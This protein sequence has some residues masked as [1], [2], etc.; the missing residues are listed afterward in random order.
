M[1]KKPVGYAVAVIEDPHYEK[2]LI[3]TDEVYTATR[4]KWS[5]AHGATVHSNLREARECCM[6]ANWDSCCHY[7]IICILE[8]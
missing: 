7:S 6:R 4:P 1:I 8:G 3:G 2:A 5:T